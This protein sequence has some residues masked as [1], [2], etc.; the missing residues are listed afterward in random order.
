MRFPGQQFD[1]ETGLHYNYYRDY[2]PSTG[3]YIQ[4]GTATWTAINYSLSPMRVV[5]GP[6]NWQQPVS[7]RLSTRDDLTAAAPTGSAYR[8]R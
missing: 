3:R 6:D 5:I 1:R 2:D 8:A 7:L 4:R